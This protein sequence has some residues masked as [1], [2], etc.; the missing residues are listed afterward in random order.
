[1]VYIACLYSQFHILGFIFQA[2][3]SKIYIPILYSRFYLPGFIFQVSYSR[4]YIPSFIFQVYI[5]RGVQKVPKGAQGSLKGY[6]GYQK[7]IREEVSY[8]RLYIHG[9]YCRFIFQVSYSRFYI[10]GFIFKD[11]YT[12]LIFQ[13]FV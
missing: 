7:T 1:M 9:L 8:S 2:L 6:P 12:M 10:A 3:Y 11:S 5:T 4:F 13:V